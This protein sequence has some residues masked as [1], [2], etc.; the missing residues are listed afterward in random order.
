MTHRKK[1]TAGR[2][3]YDAAIVLKWF[4]QH[5]LFPVAEYKFHETR[6]W[7]FDFAFPASLVALEVE[8]GVWTGG[9]HTTPAGYV[10]DIE[11]YNTAGSMGWIVLRVTPDELGMQETVEM[12]KK[13]STARNTPRS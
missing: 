3:N 9:R 1:L 12:I 11:K 2:S 4:A 6:K 8:G 5:D 7:R 10:K 13:A